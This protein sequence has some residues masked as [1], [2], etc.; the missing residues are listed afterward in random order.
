MNVY[1]DICGI[2]SNG[3]MA[4]DKIILSNLIKRAEKLVV[5]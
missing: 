3:G 5:D 4:I 2:V 1:G